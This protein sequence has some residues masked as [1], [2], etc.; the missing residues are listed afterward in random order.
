MLRSRGSRA[1]TPRLNQLVDEP[2]GTSNR[3]LPSARARAIP[4]AS[5]CLYVCSQGNGDAST[6]TYRSGR[7]AVVSAGRR[8]VAAVAVVAGGCLSP[9]RYVAGAVVAVVR[10][11]VVAAS[12]ASVVAAVAFLVALP[13]RLR[14]APHPRRVASVALRGRSPPLR[15]VV[16][17][18]TASAPRQIND[19]RIQFLKRLHLRRDAI[20]NGP[21]NAASRTASINPQMI[22]N[23]SCR[24]IACCIRGL[25]DQNRSMRMSAALR[26]TLPTTRTA[27]EKVM[28]CEAAQ[29]SEPTAPDQ[30]T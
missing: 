26:T 13:H 8:S 23:P 19:L 15:P 14:S 9:S 17:G 20:T 30:E 24:S 11:S 3:F 5:P 16:R 25:R 21:I 22:Q 7:Q 27:L 29:R 12:V 4:A 2:G 18:L 10:Q 28:A 6:H 1:A